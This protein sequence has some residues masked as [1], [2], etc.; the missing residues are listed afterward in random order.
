MLAEKVVAP[1]KIAFG[2]E[3]RIAFD[4]PFY[5]QANISYA[6]VLLTNSTDYRLRIANLG[7]RG[8]RC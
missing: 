8:Q 7:Q 3:T 6:V 2:G 4:D 5:A 1:D